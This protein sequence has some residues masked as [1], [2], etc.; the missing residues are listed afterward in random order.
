MLTQLWLSSKD[1]GVL[2]LPSAFLGGSAP[3]LQE[4]HLEG[5]SFPALPTFLSSATYLVV[6]HL[7]RI[8][9]AGYISPEVMV[10]NLA[11]LTRLGDLSIEFQ[12]STSTPDQSGTRGQATPLTRAVLPALTSFEFRGT[13]DYL[14]NL[15]AQIDAPRLTSIKITYFDQ[16]LLQVPQL[17]RFA[18][19]TQVLEPARFK[20]AQANFRGTHVYIGLHSEQAESGRS[21]FS[22]RILC[23]RLDW[24]VLRLAEVL[25][26]CS[27]LLSNVD[28]VSI[29]TYD[30]QSSWQGDM[31]H[32]AWLELLRQF[33]AVKALRVSAHLAGHV[34]DALKD[35][36]VE[37]V[38]EIMPVLRL[39]FL[40]D[41]PA[42]RV[43][44]FVLRRQHFGLPV[45]V[46]N[47]PHEFLRKR[48]YQLL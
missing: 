11:T 8:P 34:A 19:Q 13:S 32:H 22:L 3:C 2:V 45:T 29:G 36:T 48:E 25:S 12:S 47:S 6:L 30:L 31:G 43:G 44:D 14:E 21:H 23:Q 41:E 18:E 38:P 5:I 27:P 10:A 17:F 4:I 26:Q 37:M 35:V 40:E 33:T 28:Q 46:A 9:Y 42:R 1:E 24:Q 15:V 16:P 7:H 39:L 20:Y